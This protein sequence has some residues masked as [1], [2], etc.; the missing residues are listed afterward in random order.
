M[1]GVPAA[2]RQALRT[3]VLTSRREGAAKSKTPQMDQ[4]GLVSDSANRTP[5]L[6]TAFAAD[7]ER[8]S[9]WPVFQK[10]S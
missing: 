1:R 2:C 5:N 8:I 3:V 7:P 9:H 10:G 6:G 4:D